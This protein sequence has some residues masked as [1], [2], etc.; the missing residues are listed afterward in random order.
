MAL[1]TSGAISLGDIGTEF[2]DTAP[3]SL[4]EFYGADTGIPSSGEIVLVIFMVH[5]QH[6]H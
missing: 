2:S 1:Q 6:P 3:H 5:L 4:S